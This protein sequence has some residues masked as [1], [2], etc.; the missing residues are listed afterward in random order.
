M[1]NNPSHRP[2]ERIAGER[3]SADTRAVDNDR[4]TAFKQRVN[5]GELLFDHAPAQQNKTALQ[6]CKVPI[7]VDV[8]SI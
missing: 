4:V 6:P 5:R 8:R 1:D 2:N 3:A 7:R